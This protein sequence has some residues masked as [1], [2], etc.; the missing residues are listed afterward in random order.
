MIA[1][2]PV[3]TIKQKFD[4]VD[5]QQVAKFSGA[6]TVHVVDAMDGHGALDYR[7]KPLDPGSA[8]FAGPA[9]TCHAGADD[10]LAILAAFAVARPG[11]VIVAATDGFTGS[12]VFGDL[13]ARYASNCGIVAVVTDG[14]ARDTA[15]IIDTGLPVFV[16][17]VTPGS[18]AR[19]GPGTVGLPIVIGRVSV[20]AGDLIVGDRDGVVVVPRSDVHAVVARLED[21]RTAESVF[22]ADAETGLHVPNF[23]QELL[24]SEKVRY[25]D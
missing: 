17:G 25:L 15:G 11:D 7:I 21:V 6:Q 14:L 3:L 24:Q 16:G 18:S 10:N 20:S 12:A 8:S 19:S 2:P 13:F 4:R 23:M 22:E 1:D 5:P 9:L